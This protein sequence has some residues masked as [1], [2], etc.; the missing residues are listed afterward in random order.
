MRAPAG[1]SAGPALTADRRAAGTHG[2]WFRNKDDGS[3]TIPKG[4]PEPGEE[5][6]A[7]AVREFAEE[8]GITVPAAGPFMPL[9]PVTQK[10]GKIVHAWAFEGHCDPSAIRSNTFMIEPTKDSLLDDSCFRGRTATVPRL[11]P[12]PS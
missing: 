6:L 9:A 1:P 4:E 2:R 12:P 10:G 11:R 7:A 3:W 5:L 8:T